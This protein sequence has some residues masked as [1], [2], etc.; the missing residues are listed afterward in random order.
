MFNDLNKDLF[1]E[2]IEP[3]YLI[4]RIFRTK[5]WVL[6]TPVN[7]SAKFQVY[8]V[9]MKLRKDIAQ[10]GFLGTRY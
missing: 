2:I 4:T 10:H 9:V 5:A 7:G 8:Q 1:I 6:V 3:P